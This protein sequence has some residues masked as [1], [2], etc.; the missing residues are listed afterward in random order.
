MAPALARIVAYIAMLVLVALNIG[1]S[2]LPI[3]DYRVAAQIAIAVATALL[4]FL[5]FMRLRTS[6][7]LVQTIACGTVLW[8][9][10]MF[11]FFFLDYTHR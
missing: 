8:I 5:I 2:F 11:G 6:P 7:Q 3:S 9:L 1:L 4:I 10:I